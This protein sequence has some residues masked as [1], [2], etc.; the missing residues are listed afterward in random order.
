[1]TGSG[2]AGRRAVSDLF[3]RAVLPP[4]AAGTPPQAGDGGG[5]V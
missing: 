4:A 1:M 5:Q 3:V 2:G